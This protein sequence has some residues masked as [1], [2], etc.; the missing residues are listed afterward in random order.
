MTD[1]SEDAFDQVRALTKLLKSSEKRYTSLLKRYAFLEDEFHQLRKDLNKTRQELDLYKQ[2]VFSKN[3]KRFRSLHDPNDQA[4]E[5]KRLN[6]DSH[7]AR[8]R[9]SRRKVAEGGLLEE[10]S[11][12]GGANCQGQSADMTISEDNATLPVTQEIIA[13]QSR[14]HAKVAQELLYEN[15]DCNEVI[16]SEGVSNSDSVLPSTTSLNDDA[17]ESTNQESK[18]V[19]KNSGDSSLIQIKTDRDSGELLDFSLT[20]YPDYKIVDK[21]NNKVSRLFEKWYYTNP[22]IDI[23][24]KSNTWPYLMKIKRQKMV[25]TTRKFVIIFV[26]TFATSWC[27]LLS[28]QDLAIFDYHSLNADTYAIPLAFSKVLD[29]YLHFNK[30]SIVNFGKKLQQAYHTHE[31]SQNDLLN[32][33]KD[34]VFNFIKLRQLV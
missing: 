21:H 1:F 2:Y 20:E 9:R 28:E 34:S 3:F 4:D 27:F 5:K 26:F 32:E 25:Y 30:I 29:L 19:L 17:S 7:G 11:G 33:I 6:E 13:A 18:S 15:D 23:V 16:S 22:T 31:L 8:L 12:N 10:E 24:K 14:L